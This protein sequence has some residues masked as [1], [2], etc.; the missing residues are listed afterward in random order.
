MKLCLDK[1][2]FHTKPSKAHIP[3]INERIINCVVDVSISTLA[4]QITQPNGRTWTPAYFKEDDDIVK[5]TNSCWAGQ[6]IFAL[7]FDEGITV[8]EVIIRCKKYHVMPAFIY[9]TF[10]SV[11]NNKFRVVFQMHFEIQDIRVRN[12]IQYALLVL[13]KE[14]D[15]NCKDA[16]RMFYGGKELIYTDYDIKLD[17]EY[18]IMG[19]CQYL[20]ESDSKHA[21][22]QVHKYCERVGLD[23]I[24]GIPKITNNKAIMGKLVESEHN[25]YIYYRTCPK[26]TKNDDNVM[27]AATVPDHSAQEEVVIFFND[28]VKESVMRNEKQSSKFDSIN[29]VIERIKSRNIDLDKLMSDCKL[30]SD[31]ITGQYWAYHHEVFGIATNVLTVRGGKEKFMQGIYSRIE[32]DKK[33]WSFIANYINKMDYHPQACDNFCPF[34]NDCEHARNM[35]EQIKIFRGR[36]N[37]INTLPLITLAEAEIRVAKEFERVVASKENKVYVIKAPTGIGKTELYLSLKNTTVA[38]PRHNLKAEVSERMKARG[39]RHEAIPEL[40]KE[41][42]GFLSKLNSLYSKGHYEGATALKKEMAKHDKSME[43]YLKKLDLIKDCDCTL[44][45]T[46]ERLLYTED[47]NNQ[48]VIDE[49]II[50]TLLKINKV[51][52]SDLIVISN[53][54]NLF[55]NIS[56]TVNNAEIGVVNSVS[57]E[58]RFE[59]ALVPEQQ[60]A[61]LKQIE[62]LST[63][64]VDFLGCSHW[65]K[66]NDD[67]ISYINIRELP[68]KKTIIMSATADEYIYKLLFGNRLEFIDIGEVEKKGKLIQYPQ[69]SFSRYRMQKD[70]QLIQMAKIIAGDKPVITF[71]GYDIYFPNCV[72]TFGNLTGID[73]LSGKDIVIV[74]TPHINP[75]S[76][77]LY[78]HALKV[79]PLP[80]N[81]SMRYMQVRRN[82][83]EFYMFTFDDEGLREIQLYLIESELLQAVGRARLLRQECTVIVMSSMPLVGAEFKY[84]SKASLE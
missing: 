80:S 67:S 34:C 37:I 1:G 33:K 84:L 60:K 21:S 20:Q 36:V 77:L 69:W 65:I 53:R 41:N 74:G 57:M 43:E 32:Y 58:M 19:M 9:T 76:Y 14:A 61:F 5:R 83:M 35:I 10:S 79:N 59:L 56:E 44:L 7:D 11:N 4:K 82:G 38:L 27:V 50:A 54:T 52:I 71:K 70:D 49:D 46:H 75:T 63:N 78:A 24:N 62:V 13:F 42:E 51:S 29:D 48:I 3:E 68:Q 28:T 25:L 8:E 72:A 2:I 40:P 17:I 81:T 47:N 31:F 16:S 30:Y 39:N 45:T 23:R 64:V 18:L 55:P 26:I 22:R 6:T 73:A 66:N 15:K 12:A